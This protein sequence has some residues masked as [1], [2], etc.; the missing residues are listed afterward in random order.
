MGTARP[1]QLLKYWV[2]STHSQPVQLKKGVIGHCVI[3]TETHYS[4]G[5]QYCHAN[6][7]ENDYV[8]DENIAAMSLYICVSAIIF[9]F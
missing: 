1:R 7:S 9:V 5:T 2:W 8:I 3:I 4:A 6:R